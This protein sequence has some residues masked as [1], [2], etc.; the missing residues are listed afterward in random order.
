MAAPMT[1]SKA[2]R[3]VILK[4]ISESNRCMHDY[5]LQ[6]KD[7]TKWLHMY[8]DGRLTSIILTLESSS[9]KI[10]QSTLMKQGVMDSRTTA[11]LTLKA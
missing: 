11:T 9:S 7:N 8:V 3:C 4:G 1:D 10:T 6:T 2:A 5:L